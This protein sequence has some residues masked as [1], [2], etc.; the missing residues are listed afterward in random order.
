MIK[1]LHLY[2]DLLN[3]YGEQGN[4]LA[5][6]R[7]FKNQNVDIQIDFL[8]INDKIDFKKYELIYLGSGSNENLYITID[9]IKKHK[10]NL[11]KFIENNKTIIATG[12]SF[13][14]FGSKINEIETLGIFNYYSKSSSKE[15]SESLMEL[16]NTKNIIGFQNKT[17]IVNIKNNHLFKVKYGLADNQKSE[18]EGFKYKNFYGT[19]LLGPLLIRNPHFTNLIVKNILENNNLIFH[20]YNDEILTKPYNEY[21]NNFYQ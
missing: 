13:L 9:D 3:L 15:A 16:D 4:I 10:K 5:L 19:S 18:H 17:Y 1:I 2:Y 14:L 8:S 6:K 21:I 7:A 12:N 11:E 20:E